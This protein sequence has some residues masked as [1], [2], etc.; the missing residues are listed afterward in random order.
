MAIVCIKGLMDTIMLA[1]FWAC[2]YNRCPPKLAKICCINS[3]F[4]Q[5]VVNVLF[6]WSSQIKETDAK[7]AAAN[8][9]SVYAG[10]RLLVVAASSEIEKT[11]WLED[12]RMVIDGCNNELESE[13]L[14]YASLKSTS[15]SH[16]LLLS[17]QHLISLRTRSHWYECESRHLCTSN[18]KHESAYIPIAAVHNNAG[19]VYKYELPWNTSTGSFCDSSSFFATKTAK[20]DAS[21]K[22]LA[23]IICH[24]YGARNV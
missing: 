18:S 13:E 9:F 15:E 5:L 7:M 12:L 19:S 2:Y 11:K 3:Y 20:T 21:H 24:Y 17:L 6:R 16:H 1:V 8:S 23:S 10:N 14:R 22:V 4:Y